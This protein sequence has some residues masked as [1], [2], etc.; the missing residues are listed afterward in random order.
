MSNTKLSDQQ[1][2]AYKA[3][4]DFLDDGGKSGS[5]MLLG[6]YAGTG[7]TYLVSKIIDEF[8]RKK[9]RIALSAPTKL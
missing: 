7:K 9:K 4:S 2:K 8:S 3:I 6:G 5:M 1:E